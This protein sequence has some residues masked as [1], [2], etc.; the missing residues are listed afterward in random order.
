M[1]NGELTQEVKVEEDCHGRKWYR[2]SVELYRR[3]HE[4]RSDLKEFTARLIAA[5]QV[6]EEEKGKRKKF[7]VWISE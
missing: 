2:S 4:W 6:S 7:S 3:A 5:D 1:K